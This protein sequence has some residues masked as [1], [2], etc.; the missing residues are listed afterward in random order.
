MDILVTAIPEAEQSQEGK[1]VVWSTWGKWLL[2]E[3]KI[4]RTFFLSEQ[5]LQQRLGK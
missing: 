3:A 5:G 1:Y 4:P 2:E